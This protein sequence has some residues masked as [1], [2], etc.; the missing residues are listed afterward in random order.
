[1]AERDVVVAVRSRIV[2]TVRCW[3]VRAIIVVIA[4]P[5]G[6]RIVGVGGF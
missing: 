2:V 5:V 6:T 4:T 3:I 1:M